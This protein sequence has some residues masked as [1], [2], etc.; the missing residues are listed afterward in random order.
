MG[1]VYSATHTEQMG[2]NG[3]DDDDKTKPQC[4]GVDM[5][6]CAASLALIKYVCGESE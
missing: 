1:G 6:V 5:L 3:D 4:M 2:K